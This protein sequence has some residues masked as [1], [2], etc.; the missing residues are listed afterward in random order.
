MV[1]CAVNMLLYR[2]NVFPKGVSP[3]VSL[4]DLRED[5]KMAKMFGIKTKV[6]IWFSWMGSASE[7][8]KDQTLEA[9]SGIL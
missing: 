6:G 1:Y 9:S 2:W 4:K 5:G 8:A 7:E 3:K